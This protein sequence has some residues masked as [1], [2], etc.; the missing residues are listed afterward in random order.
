MPCLG[1]CFCPAS[2]PILSDSA[3]GCAGQGL[4]I[5]LRLDL[6]PWLLKHKVVCRPGRAR[7]LCR[8]CNTDKFQD[9]GFRS[10]CIYLGCQRLRCS[11]MVRSCSLQPTAELSSGEDRLLRWQTSPYSH[12]V[13]TWL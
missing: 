6:T 1:L 4:C 5:P 7:L 9:W 12:Q 10:R 13:L 3:V 2:G 8:L 11:L